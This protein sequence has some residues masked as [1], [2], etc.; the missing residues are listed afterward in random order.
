MRVRRNA[1][2][3]VEQLRSIHGVPYLEREGEVAILHLGCAERTD[4]S[5]P[6]NRF[7]PEWMARFHEL[8]DEVEAESGP[9]AVVTVGAG[10]YYSTGADLDWGAQHPDEI[11]DYLS[12]IQRLFARVLVSPVPMIA[13]LQGHAFGAGAFLALAHDR[14][15]MREDRGYFCFPGITIGTSYA[16]GTVALAA[17]RLNPRTAHEALTTGRRYSGPQAL[18]RGLVDDLAPLE[19]VLATAVE[20]AKNVA[21]TRGPV[22]ADIKFR[23]HR[24]AQAQLLTPVGGYNNRV[25]A[26]GGG[27]RDPRDLRDRVPQ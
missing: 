8:L 17:A 4:N 13:A 15:V 19:R 10:K 23:L 12:D 25:P 11:D 5:N 24:E 18:A 20:Y 26:A 22:L 14:A 21:H 2:A 16:P 3:G 6:E 7:R 1:L 9:R 27:A